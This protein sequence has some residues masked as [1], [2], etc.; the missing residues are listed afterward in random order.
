M[1]AMQKYFEYKIVL[2]CGVPKVKLLGTIDDWI[3]LRQMTEKLR[4][5]DCDW[6]ID[7]LMP[8]IDKLIRAYEG[9]IDKTFWNCIY[10]HRPGGGSGPAS[11]ATGWIINFFPYVENCKKAKFFDITNLKKDD[12]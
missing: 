4:S 12:K 8:V 2:L 10:V 9:E 3:L 1:D 11:K 7:Y 6:W 5:Y